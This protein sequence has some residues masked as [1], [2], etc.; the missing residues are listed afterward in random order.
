MR[1]FTSILSDRISS[2]GVESARIKE[3]L[4]LSVVEAVDA[5]ECDKGICNDT[6][7]KG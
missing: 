6:A 5:I 2:W 4:G 7:S 3:A 1:L